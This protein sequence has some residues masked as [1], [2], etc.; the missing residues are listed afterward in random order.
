MKGMNLTKIYLSTFINGITYPQCNNMVIKSSFL[1][2]IKFIRKIVIGGDGL[3]WK[4][5]KEKTQIC[6]LQCFSPM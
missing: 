1:L 5:Q 3:R 6:R 2:K 4:R